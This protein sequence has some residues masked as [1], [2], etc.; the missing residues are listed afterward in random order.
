MWTRLRRPWSPTVHRTPGPTSED[1]VVRRSAGRSDPSARRSSSDNRQH[2]GCRADVATGVASPTHGA[3]GERPPRRRASPPKRARPRCFEAR[4]SPHHGKTAV[5]R[6][7]PRC[8][9]V[10]PIARATRPPRIHHSGRPGVATETARVP[11]QTMPPRLRPRLDRDGSEDPPTARRRP[12]ADSG[13]K[14]PSSGNTPLERCHSCRRSTPGERWTLRP[15]T[16]P[17]RALARGGARKH[18]PDYHTVMERNHGRQAILCHPRCR[19]LH[20]QCPLFR[21]SK[22]FR[23]EREPGIECATS[24]SCQRHVAS[25]RDDGRSPVHRPRAA[26]RRPASEPG[27]NVAPTLPPRSSSECPRASP[28][29]TCKGSKSVPCRLASTR[30]GVS[31]PS[32]RKLR[33]NARHRR[34][35]QRR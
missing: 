30:S 7:A 14:R 35:R 21:A 17:R 31:H 6:P 18:L 24:S 29:G 9:P 1:A 34:G 4:A 5:R 26:Y 22:R 27:R 10:T 25:R 33:G 16:S 2:L 8:Q 23:G 28:P 19:C 20:Q 12:A 13:R 15:D 32:P 11:L 3:H